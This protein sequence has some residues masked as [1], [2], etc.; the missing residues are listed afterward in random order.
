MS[1]VNLLNKVFWGHT[2]L[3]HSFEIK[4][5]KIDNKNVVF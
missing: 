3:I 4:F 5:K 2:N 1:D